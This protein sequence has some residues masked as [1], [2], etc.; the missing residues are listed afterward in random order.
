MAG[1][2]TFRQLEC[3]V[4]KA[5]ANIEAQ[6]GGLL[7]VSHS[8][9]F[10]LGVIAIMTE[11]PALIEGHAKDQEHFRAALPH[12]G[13]IGREGL[14]MAAEIASLIEKAASLTHAGIAKLLPVSDRPIG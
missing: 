11:N 4:K 2:S 13:R 8:V 9:G 12:S 14:A 10:L 6:T 7:S 5:E 3:R 1:G